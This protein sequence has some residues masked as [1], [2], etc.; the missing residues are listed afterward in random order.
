MTDAGLRTAIA[1]RSCATF[2][3]P[4]VSVAP[5]SV[6]QWLANSR[7]S[8]PA[9]TAAARRSGSTVPLRSGWHAS[10]AY[11]VRAAMSHVRTRDLHT[12]QREWL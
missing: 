12:P 10:H 1:S 4:G 11:T 2:I 6:A 3:L 8:R 5:P 9:A 7:A